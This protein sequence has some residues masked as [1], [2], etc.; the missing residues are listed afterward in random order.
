MEVVNK[1]VVAARDESDNPFE[2]IEM[3]MTVKE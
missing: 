2:P 3:K 1:I